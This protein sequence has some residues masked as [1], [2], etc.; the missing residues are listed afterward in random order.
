MAQSDGIVVTLTNE[1]CALPA[2]SNLPV[3]A[4]WAEKG[5]THEGCYGVSFGNVLMYF[6]DRTVVSLPSRH[7]QPARGI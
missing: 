5:K 2:V 3:R 7:F 4:T 6:D 1:K